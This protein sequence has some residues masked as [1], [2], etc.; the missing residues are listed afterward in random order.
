MSLREM[1]VM[2]GFHHCSLAGVH[3]SL[4]CAGIARRDTISEYYINDSNNPFSSVDADMRS[5][6]SVC[7]LEPLKGFTPSIRLFH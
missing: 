5:F 6:R 1:G 4:Y 7:L 3:C 2:D